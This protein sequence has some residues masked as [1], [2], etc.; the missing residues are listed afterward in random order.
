MYQLPNKMVLV[1]AESFISELLL[2]SFSD[3]IFTASIRQIN[4]QNHYL[5]KWNNFCCFHVV[6]SKKWQTLISTSRNLVIIRQWNIKSLQLKEKKNTKL[7]SN[8]ARL[9]QNRIYQEAI[10]PDKYPR[11]IRTDLPLLIAEEGYVLDTIHL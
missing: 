10:P 4:M 3:I 2:S 6:H 11:S 5:I 7:L 9:K 8:P 1:N